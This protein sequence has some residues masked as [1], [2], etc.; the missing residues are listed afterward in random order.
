[1]KKRILS[2][3]LSLSFILPCS[4][5]FAGCFNTGC[6]VSFET[7]DGTNIP[8]RH[9]EFQSSIN[10][11]EFPKPTKIGFKFV[12]WFYEDT[13]ENEVT[14]NMVAHNMSVTYYAKYELDMDYYEYG[15][16]YFI[17]T[18]DRA[19]YEIAQTPANSSLILINKSNTL[20]TFDS[21][22]VRPRET[23]LFRCFD[24]KVYD[25]NGKIIKDKNINTTIFEAE[26]PKAEAQRF[27][28]KVG[29][30]YP[31]DYWISIN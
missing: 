25:E 18:N 20:D 16:N 13:F 12:G 17:W 11:S 23:S 30:Q 14:Q 27:V 29:I 6:S 5:M 4:L 31:G 19:S 3:L 2:F 28:V 15:S 1:M 8:S 7:W 21:V 26:N 24:V 22:S 9:Y 10:P